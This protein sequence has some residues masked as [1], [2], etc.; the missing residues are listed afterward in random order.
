VTMVEQVNT[1]HFSRSYVT[2]ARGHSLYKQIF[3]E[4]LKQ[5][6]ENNIHQTRK[7]CMYV[8]SNWLESVMP[9]TVSQ[10]QTTT[11]H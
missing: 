11:H 1:C 4:G 9:I 10:N 2:A 8:Y 7:K 5:K 3:H 6:K